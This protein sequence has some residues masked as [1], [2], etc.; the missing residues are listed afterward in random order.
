MMHF[1]NPLIPSV[2]ALVSS[3]VAQTVQ[4]TNG[5][6]Q[7][8]KCARS[9]SNYFLSI[10]YA[11]PPVGDLRLKAPQTLASAYDGTLNATAE[12]PSCLQFNELFAESNTQS[13]DCLYLNVWAPSTATPDSKLPVKVWIYG[14]ANQAGGISDPTYDGCYATT[15]SIIVSINYRVGP[16]GFLALSSLGLSGN[17][18][19][20]DQLLGLQWVQDNI[21]AFGGDTSK[22][23]LFGQS[24]GAIDAYILTTLPQAPQL[25]SAAALESGGGRD[26]PTVQKAQRWNQHFIDALNCS[27]TDLTCVLTASGSDIVTA[28]A[29]MPAEPAP[30]ATTPFNNDGAR[31][32]WGP[33]VDGEVVPVTPTTAGNK[34]PAIFGSNAAEGTLFVFGAYLE[35]SF[36]LN[37]TVYDEFLT[38]N[39]GPLASK[40][41]QTYSVD[42]FNSSS[43]PYFAA[44]STILGD[45][46]YKCPAYRGLVKS[47]QL[48]IPAWT[49]EFSHS[50]SCAWYSAIPDEILKYV[51]ATHT[52]EIPFVFNM[53][54]NMPPPDGN[55]TFTTKEQALSASMSQAWTNMALLGNPGDDTV[56]PQWST[57]S[58]AGVNIDDSMVA[59]TVDYTSC[60][61]WDAIYEESLEI[62]GSC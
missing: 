17:Y 21:A 14:G 45:V 57:N 5:T 30:G 40:V 50:P 3:S 29:A 47:Q 38:Y 11:Q 60:L 12:A 6:I 25:F 54:H 20:Q 10:P 7:G 41:N 59:G 13:E 4:V 37:Q 48:G 24:A 42:K 34:V 53:T 15:D 26:P 22:V 28:N 39:F 35:A 16:L 36:A 9:D 32:T 33:L 46:S 51:G 19:L 8:G 31:A 18:G 23:L 58:S 61:F 1:S 2:L 55:C 43:Y 62:V 44:I 56:W 49:Y 27:S 52:A